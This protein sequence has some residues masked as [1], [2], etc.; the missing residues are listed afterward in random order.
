[1]RSGP[2]AFWLSFFLT[3]AI[4]I[5]LLGSFVLYGLWQRDTAAPA[6][7]TQSGVPVG[8]PGQENDHTLFV[9][10]AAEQPGFVLLRLDGVNGVIRICPLPAESVVAAPSGPMQLGERAGRRNC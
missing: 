4:L 5:P 10:V 8:S 7:I 1:M 3:L 6:Q 2:K 9:A